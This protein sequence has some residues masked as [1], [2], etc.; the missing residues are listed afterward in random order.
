[1]VYYNLSGIYAFCGN[2]GELDAVVDI[3]GAGN[4]SGSIKDT[5][6]TKVVSRGEVMGKLTVEELGVSNVL[7]LI[8]QIN[9]SAWD[10][11]KIRLTNKTLGI[12]GIYETPKKAEDVF[13][14]AQLQ[15]VEL[16]TILDPV[17]K[18]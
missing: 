2:K 5:S 16:T 11:S 6:Y 9:R 18:D 3:D 12:S 15:S 10:D 17:K 8:I 14:K 7:E 4:I 13:G 1:M